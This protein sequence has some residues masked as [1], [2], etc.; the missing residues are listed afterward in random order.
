MRHCAAIQNKYIGRFSGCH[1]AAAGT[2]Q[3]TS[4]ALTLSLI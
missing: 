1:N 2:H 4:E 3:F